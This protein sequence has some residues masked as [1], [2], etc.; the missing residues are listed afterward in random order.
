MSD[1]ISLL[2]KFYIFEKL[3][4]WAD[5][6]LGSVWFWLCFWFFSAQNPKRKPTVKCRWDLGRLGFCDEWCQTPP[7][8]RRI[9]L[10]MTDER[11]GWAYYRTLPHGATVANYGNSMRRVGAGVFAPSLGF[12]VLGEKTGREVACRISR[13]P[14]CPVRQGSR[15][16]CEW[17]LR[18]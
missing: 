5:V 7:W 15:T 1:H 12:T 4:M 11:L 2:N 3:L 17:L 10:C 14:S 16:G 6:V 8:S 18:K 9:S 13:F